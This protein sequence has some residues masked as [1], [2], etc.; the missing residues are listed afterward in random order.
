MNLLVNRFTL[1]YIKII[2]AFHCLV[3]NN[4]TV[5]DIMAKIV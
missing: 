2:M 5:Y 4:Q 1:M 3:T